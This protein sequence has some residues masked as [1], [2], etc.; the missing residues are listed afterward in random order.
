MIDPSARTRLGGTQVEGWMQ[1]LADCVSVSVDAST[2][3]ETAAIG[4]AFCARVTAGLEPDLTG[5]AGWA[6]PTRRF[7]PDADSANA[8]KG[9]YARFRELA[10]GS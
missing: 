10:D 8:V 2:E 7:A 4:A 1:A 5:A 9:R 6:R 3:P